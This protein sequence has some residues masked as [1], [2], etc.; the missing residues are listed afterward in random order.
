MFHLGR[1]NIGYSVGNFVYGNA[2]AVPAEPSN[3]ISD[4]MYDDIPAQ[5]K[6]KNIVI[7]I[8]INC[9]TIDIENAL[10]LTKCKRHERRITTTLTNNMQR[11]S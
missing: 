4:R 8:L 10:F 1:H 6:H 3:M 2:P 9:L 7:S 11:C 5:T